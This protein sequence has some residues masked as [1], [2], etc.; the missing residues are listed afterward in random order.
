MNATQARLHGFAYAVQRGRWS[1]Y[2]HCTTCRLDL[3]L[4][5]HPPFLTKGEATIA[6]TAHNEKAHPDA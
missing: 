2:A 5:P 6:A 3:P 4:K 1:W